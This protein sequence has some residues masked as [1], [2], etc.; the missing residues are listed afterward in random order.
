M[1]AQVSGFRKTAA[2]SPAISSYRLV[3]AVDPDTA[4]VENHQEENSTLFWVSRWP[5]PH[6]GLG[7][8]SSSTCKGSD[9]RFGVCANIQRSFLPGNHQGSTIFTIHTT[10]T[11]SR[12]CI[13]I[14]TYSN[15]TKHETCGSFTFFSFTASLLLKAGFRMDYAFCF[16]KITECSKSKHKEPG[17]RSSRDWIPYLLINF[18]ASIS[19]QHHLSCTLQRTKSPPTSVC[20]AALCTRATCGETIQAARRPWSH[21]EVKSPESLKHWKMKKC[22]SRVPVF[23]QKNIFGSDM[24]KHPKPC[25]LFKLVD[26]R[27]FTN[28]QW[29]LIVAVATADHH[30]CRSIIGF[31]NGFYSCCCCICII[32]L[33]EVSI[34]WNLRRL[35]Q[36]LLFEAGLMTQQS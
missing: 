15:A 19:F 27:W 20:P 4:G 14:P 18:K 30:H 28:D 12:H 2:I 35:S 1:S 13:N 22:G 36:D 34:S 25:F 10:T 11:V 21:G 8:H 29:V 9:S 33:R 26:D 5:S 3:A 31:Y 7:F 16:S 32:P 17:M 24:L 6:G 23:P